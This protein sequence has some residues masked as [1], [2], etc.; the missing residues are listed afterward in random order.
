MQTEITI[1]EKGKYPRTCQQCSVEYKAVMPDGKFCSDKCRGAWHRKNK[2]T[3]QLTI[4]HESQRS[5][6]F[7]PAINVEPVFSGLTPHMQIAVNL[8]QKE[9]K[10]WEDSYKEER[11]TRKKIEQELTIL[12]DKVREDAHRHALGEIESDKPS[13]FERM[14]GSIPAP[15]MEQ[16]APVLGQLLS[17]VVLPAPSLAMGGVQGLDESQGQIIS[18]ITQLP[19]PLQQGVMGVLVKLSESSTP[20]NLHKSIHQINN[21]LTNGNTMHH[22]PQMFGT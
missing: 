2:T 14:L 12:K 9:S 16:I 13:T 6:N 5:K 7:L 18:W 21:L 3:G 22:Q 20:E 19:A 17:R 4:E 10:R 11:T 1:P 8:L 15:I